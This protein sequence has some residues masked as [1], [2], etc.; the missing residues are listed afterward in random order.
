MF[1][2]FVS[3]AISKVAYAIHEEVSRQHT[4]NL[5]LLDILESA[6]YFDGVFFLQFAILKCLYSGQNLHITNNFVLI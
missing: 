2:V 4:I 6:I 3:I 5:I 1:K